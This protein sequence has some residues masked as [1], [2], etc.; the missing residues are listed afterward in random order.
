MKPKDKCSTS[1]QHPKAAPSASKTPTRVKL[2]NKSPLWG[3]KEK[4]YYASFSELSEEEQDGSVLRPECK[5]SPTGSI[6]SRQRAKPQTILEVGALL[7]EV[8]HWAAGLSG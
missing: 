4:L 6:L 7:E 3:K 5:L 1:R 8:C 2:S